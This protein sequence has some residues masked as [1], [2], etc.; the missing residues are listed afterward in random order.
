MRYQHETI[1]IVCSDRTTAIVADTDVAGLTMPWT[2]TL[3]DVQA[4]L[5]SAAGSGTFTVDV[6]D[7]GTSVLSTKCT[8]DA[9]ETS[10]LTAAAPYAFTSR[11]KM[12]EIDKGTIVTID[13][14]DDAAGDAEGLIVY[15]IGLRHY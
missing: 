15:L 14:D 7:G 8:I 4:S 6:N 10:S 11:Q 5:V 9:T 13:I 2:F 3:L 12:V 1:P